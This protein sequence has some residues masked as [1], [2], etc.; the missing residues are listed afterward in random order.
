L[1]QVGFVIEQALGHITHGQNLQRYIPHDTEI[2]AHWAMPAWDHTS[3]AKNLPLYRSNWT[4]QAGLQTRG[5]IGKINRTTRLDGLFFHT[6]VTAVLAQDWLGRMPGIVS[7]DATPLQYDALGDVYEHEPGPAWLEN[8]KWRLNRDCFQKASRL[9]T[10]SEWARQSLIHDYG[11]AGE[12]ITVIPPGVNVKGW[13]KRSEPA[14]EAHPVRILFVGGNLARKG[15][16]YLLEAFHQLRNELPKGAL[17]LHLVTK[18]QVA[19]EDGLY[20]YN[21]MQPNSERLVQLYHHCDIFCLPTL[22]DCLPMVLSEAG[23]ASLP[24]ISTRV[25][26]IPEIVIEGQ[27]GLVTQPKDTGGLVA[28]LRALIASP[29]L[30]QRLGEN[31]RDLVQRQF[32]AEKNVLLLSGLI[33]E[34]IHSAQRGPQ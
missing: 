18:D 24:V 8:L 9:V 17:E 25:A 21:D 30:R 14:G 20:V 28:A 26:A 27:T 11:V 23:A 32:D 19:P 16:N 29:E 31:A 34:T 3:W 13:A 5:L 4:V 7:L 6:Q 12:K 10:W 15:G 22:G 33:K 2:N 1:Y